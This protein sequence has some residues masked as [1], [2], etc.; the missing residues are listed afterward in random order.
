MS[1]LAAIRRVVARDWTLKLSALGIALL[2]W[3]AVRFEAR[4][5][6]E[7]SSVAVRVDLSDPAWILADGSEPGSVSVRLRGPAMELLRLT[8]DRPVVVVPITEV[9]SAD[10]TVVI[11]PGWVRFGERPGV[12]VEG[13]SPGTVS[14]RFEPVER[15][16]LAPALRLTGELPR[17]LALAAEPEPTVREFRISGPRSRMVQFDSVLLRP[18]D[19]S[20][21]TQAGAVPIMVDTAQMSG[22]Q[23]QPVA[24]EVQLRVEPRVERTFLLP[25]PDLPDPPAREGMEGYPDSLTVTV[26]GAASL[27]EALV[28]GTLRLVPEFT[29][30]VEDLDTSFEVSFRLEGLPTLLQGRVDPVQVRREDP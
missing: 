2:L 16:T 19:L 29:D 9:G 4:N 17:D 15:L 6:Q 11:Q 25:A 1:S 14:L 18:L 10:T 20:E 21:I 27:V 5:Q 3:F 7:I 26:S 28:P 24:L 30:D 8:S 23:V 22:L 13:I 12:L